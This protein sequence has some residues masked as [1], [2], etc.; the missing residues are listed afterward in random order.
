MGDEQAALDHLARA[1]ELDPRSVNVARE[2]ADALLDFHLAVEAQHEVERGLAVEPMNAALLTREALVALAQGDTVAAR[3]AVARLGAGFEAGA[4]M[5]GITWR[6]WL[7]TEEQQRTYLRLPP[8]P[9]GGNRTWQANA[10]AILLRV[11]GDSTRMRAY[12]D[13]GLQAIK[14]D[15]PPDSASLLPSF[16]HAIRGMLLGM[17]GRPREAD[18]EASAAVQ[19]LSDRYSRYLAAY[20]KHLAAWTD[21][22]AGEN[23]SAITLLEQVVTAPYP[24]TRAYLRVDPTWGPLRG[25]PR[26]ERLVQEQKR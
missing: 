10:F 6:P 4:V 2:A 19:G 25:N 18:V 15:W 23:E 17:R 14:V 5:T 13:S 1:R 24:V 3:A 20:I 21:V 26:F 9:F 7:L 12:A 11:R 8:D 16:Q 22:L